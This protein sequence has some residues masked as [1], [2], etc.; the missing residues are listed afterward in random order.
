MASWLEDKAC[1][2]ER[3]CVWW[4]RRYRLPNSLQV[5]PDNTAPQCQAFS[6]PG[7]ENSCQAKPAGTNSA[8]HGE[9]PSTP[10][11][12]R[13]SLWLQLPPHLCERTH[14][15]THTLHNAGF[16]YDKLAKN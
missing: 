9:P 3:V 4:A 12:S 15:H 2:G 8:S 1:Y 5:G 10:S 11:S 13:P 7:S 14:T 6:V 16:N